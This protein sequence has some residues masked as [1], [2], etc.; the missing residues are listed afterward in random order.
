M[1]RHAVGEMDKRAIFQ[2]KWA[3]FDRYE[4]IGDHIVPAKTGILEEYDPWRIYYDKRFNSKGQHPPYKELSTIG[5]MVWD[6]CRRDCDQHRKIEADVIEF[7]NKYGLLGLLLQ[8]VHHVVQ[9]SPAERPLVE[10]SKYLQDQGMSEV[11]ANARAKLEAQKERPAYIRYR[12]DGSGDWIKQRIFRLDG[13]DEAQKLEAWTESSVILQSSIDSHDLVGE[14]IETTWGRYFPGIERSAN[15]FC[16]YP[17]PLSKEFWTVYGEPLVDFLAA[18]VAV[19]KWSEGLLYDDG[20]KDKS[21]VDQK[22]AARINALLSINA[23]TSSITPVLKSSRNGLKQIWRSSSLLGMLTMMLATDV[24]GGYRLIRCDNCNY[25]FASKANH[26]RH[27]SDSCRHSYHNKN[28]L[29]TA[30]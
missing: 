30:K 13:V 10:I 1:Y 24:S 21:T 6:H 18:A 28:R 23:V 14:S 15:N 2:G 27:C 12:R 20:R 26:A 8:R 7:C 17:L 11:E 25:I 9:L 16:V 29:H 22:F 3:K 19:Y 5:G 4:I